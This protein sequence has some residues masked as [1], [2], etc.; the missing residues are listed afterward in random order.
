MNDFRNAEPHP[1]RRPALLR[2][3]RLNADLAMRFLAMMTFLSLPFSGTVAAENKGTRPPTRADVAEKR[4]DLKEIRGQIQALQKGVAAA[5]DKRS[6]AVERLK[7][8]EQEISVTQRTLRDLAQQQAKLQT[9]LSSLSA[10]S[11]ELETRL[12]NQHEQLGRLVYRQ[13]LQKSPDSLHLLLNGDDPNQT[14]RDLYYLGAIGRSRSHLL[15]ETESTLQRKQALA[16][17]TQARAS[18]LAAIE[19]KQKEQHGKMLAQREQRKEILETISARIADQQR[20]LGNLKRDEKQLSQLIDR[21]A[22]AIAARPAPRRETAQATP[23]PRTKQPEEIN[24]STTPDTQSTAGGFAQLKGNLRLPVRGVVTNRFGLP[25]QEGST[26]KG[27]F[28]RADQGSDVK[29]VAS[30]QIVFSD[31]MRGFGN[32]LIVDHGGKYLSIYGNNEAVLKQTGET[33]RGG[34]VI[35]S[36]GN[37]GGNPESGLYFELRYQGQPLDPLKWVNLK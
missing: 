22:K 9:S 31:W 16:D 27:L 36:V 15:Q 30:G 8:I 6:D 13:Y 2:P 29:A 3:P 24:N 18:E 35:A 34:D 12:S 17:D 14:S 7:S 32:L 25:R 11:R 23:A 26:W 10:Q 21:L 5:K 19:E 4:D 37:S 20:E 33:V 1:S 28:I